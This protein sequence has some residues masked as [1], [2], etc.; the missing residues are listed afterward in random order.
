[1]PYWE[2]IVQLV[3]K[4]STEHGAAAFDIARRVFLQQLS[5]KTGNDT[6][7]YAMNDRAVGHPDPDDYCISF[8][9]VH[10]M[11]SVMPGLKSES[12]DLILHSTGGSGEAAKAIVDYLRQKF[13]K[14][15]VIVPSMAMSA[16]T[17]LACGADSIVMGKHSFLGPIDPQIPLLTPTGYRFVAAQNILDQFDMAKRDLSAGVPVQAWG[18]ML[19]S[20]GPDLLAFCESSKGLSKDI[21]EQMLESYM[22]KDR[23]NARK[24]ATEAANWLAN[25]NNFLSHGR[26]ISRPEL[27]SRNFEI[28]ELEDDDEIQDAVCSIFHAIT[29]SFKILNIKKII[30]NQ[31]GAAYISTDGPIP[32]PS[33]LRTMEVSSTNDASDAESSNTEPEAS[34]LETSQE[35]K[36][37]QK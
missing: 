31:H 10:G 28:E 13:K 26:F 25:H 22:F 30:E 9:D 15:R 21:V 27:K 1:M 33:L 11:M 29:L 35:P 18:S 14:I 24:E 6:I 17:M 4:W 12:L 7:I 37:Q 3:N 32:M 16:G 20:Y 23:A 34:T 8:S 19:S 36:L 5:E 2:E